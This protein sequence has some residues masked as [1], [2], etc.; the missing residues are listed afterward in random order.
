MTCVCVCPAMKRLRE[1][2][3]EFTSVQRCNNCDTVLKITTIYGRGVLSRGLES[4]S[5]PIFLI[6]PTPEADQQ[7][8]CCHVLLPPHPHMSWVPLAH[9]SCLAL[10]RVSLRTLFLDIFHRP[11]H[12]NTLWYRHC[13]HHMTLLSILIVTQICI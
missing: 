10:G 3:E 2:P 4:E 1:T 8:D 11:S 13:F 7:E 5:N 6:V 9:S 12:T